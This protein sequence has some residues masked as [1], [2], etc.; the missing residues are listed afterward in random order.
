MEQKPQAAAQINPSHPEGLVP[1][2]KDHQYDVIP[3]LI[4]PNIR[5][6]QIDRDDIIDFYNPMAKHNSLGNYAQKDKKPES[7]EVKKEVKPVEKKEE[8]KPEQKVEVKKVEQKKE[9]QKPQAAAQID[10][11]HKTGLV[12]APKDRQYD[13]GPVQ[14]TKPLIEQNQHQTDHNDLRN[15]YN[16]DKYN[17]SEGSYA[18]KEKKVDQKPQVAAQIYPLH[19]EGLVPPPKDHQYDVIPQLI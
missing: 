1:P 11:A 15:V 4:Q 3:Q 10:P 7:K 6:N 13:N 14:M 5:E 8:K 17:T 9:E 18:Q 19:P 16:P 2:P 12:P